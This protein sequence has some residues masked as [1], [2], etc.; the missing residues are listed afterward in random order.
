ME[1]TFERANST[2]TKGPLMAISNDE[3]VTQVSTPELAHVPK[4]VTAMPLSP[5][6]NESKVLVFANSK[7][8]KRPALPEETITAGEL[9]G[10]LSTD[11]YVGAVVGGILSLFIVITLISIC[12]YLR[13]RAKRSQKWANAQAEK[14]DAE[15]MVI[16]IDPQT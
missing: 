16:T 11:R 13:Q 4:E 2:D 15:R 8:P 9:M 1:Y 12:F 7:D 14:E 5:L 10:K 6:V 3:G